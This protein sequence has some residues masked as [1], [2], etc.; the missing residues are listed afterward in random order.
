MVDA[1]LSRS[2][3]DAART[4]EEELGQKRPAQSIR[5]SLVKQHNAYPLSN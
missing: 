2:Q 3:D 5:D 1:V 4:L